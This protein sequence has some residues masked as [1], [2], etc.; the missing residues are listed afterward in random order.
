M[1]WNETV[2]VSLG[3]V[4]HI[5]NVYKFSFYTQVLKKKKTTKE[6]PLLVGERTCYGVNAELGQSR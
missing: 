6:L 5:Y 4:F 2:Y 3:S 1:L